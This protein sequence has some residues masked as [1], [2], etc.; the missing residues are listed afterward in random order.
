MDTSDTGSMARSLPRAILFDMDD[1][2]LQLSAASER[3]WRCACDRFA[4]P[5]DGLVS[6]QLYDAIHE[7]RSWFWGDPERHRKGRLNPEFARRQIVGSALHRLSVE[8]PSLVDQISDAYGA[9]TE[10]ATCPFPGAIETL[11]RLRKHAVRL[12][13]VTNGNGEHQRRK[14]EKFGLAS[15]FDCILIEG[16]FGAGKPDETVYLHVLDQLD[17]KP[18]DAWMVGDNLEWEVAAPQRLG[19]CGIWIDPSGAG[20]PSS[21]T[22]HPD[23]I[24]RSL[25][26]LL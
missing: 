16:E 25:T 5:I 22:V 17:S 13:L 24:I 9:E 20:L 4:P 1:T 14:I 19:I 23:R 11:E 21:T 8:A 2:L 3:G 12:A 18:Q 26:D 6:S 7:R 10:R 15:F